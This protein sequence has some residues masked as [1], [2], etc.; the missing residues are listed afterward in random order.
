MTRL[1]AAVII[2]HDK[3]LAIENSQEKG[4]LIGPPGGK[5]ELNESGMECVR[6]ECEDELGILVVPY[7]KLG[8]YQTMTPIGE[9]REVHTYL[10]FIDRGAPINLEPDKIKRKG[11]LTH[12]ELQMLGEQAR[13]TPNLYTALRDIKRYFFN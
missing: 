7:Q 8:V 10:A 6:R 13:L 1:A 4:G 2:E 5:I 11:W 9:W 12:R 3:M